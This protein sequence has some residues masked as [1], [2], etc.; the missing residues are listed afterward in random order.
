MQAVILCGGLGTR[1]K[2]KYKNIPK[3]LVKFKKKPNL[4]KIIDNLFNQNF[5][6]IILLTAYKNE[7]IHKSIKNHKNYKKIK[8]LNDKEFTGTGGALVGA[9]RILKEKFL[10]I[11]GDLYIDFN[12]R[13][14]F[15][16]SVKKKYNTN[17][18]I[19]PNNHPFDSDTVSYNSNDKI[20]K[21]YLKNSSKIK[22]NNAIAGIFFLKKKIIKS[23][24][25]KKNIDLVKD[26]LVKN[27]SNFVY[28]TI[29]YIKDFGTKKRIFKIK[30]QILANKLINFKTKKAAVFF[31]RDGVLNKEV[32]VIKKLNQ[33]KIIYSTIESIK[34]LNKLNIPCFLVSNQAA[35]SKKI[36]K[37]KTFENIHAKLENVLSK[38]K[39]YLDDYAYCPDFDGKKF[40]NKDFP[41]FYKYRKPN[42]GIINH[43]K[44][45][46]NLNLKK[47]YF[48]GDRDIDVLTGKKAGCKTF[49]VKSPKNKDYI[50]DVKPD[51]F[52][53][54][55]L[56]AVKKILLIK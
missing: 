15:V 46:Y 41:Y 28:K 43:F 20:K 13:K 24:Y 23:K 22:P 14:F 34:I 3:A 2:N 49:L 45:K 4:I 31:D 39:A 32:G 55:A 48:I 30:K 10:V 11:L 33:F 50:L 6:E 29:D 16:H 44:N 5:K 18:V 56:Y 42:I 8:I 26:I 25:N 36:I 53:K 37:F 1:L 52:V 51:Y 19:H 17:T 7:Q 21:F 35:L 40:S 9:N 27:K 38:N 12:Y 54:N 47:S